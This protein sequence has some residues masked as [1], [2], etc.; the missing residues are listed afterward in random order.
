M[1]MNLGCGQIYCDALNADGC[2]TSEMKFQIGNNLIQLD[3][4]SPQG[5]QREERNRKNQRKKAFKATQAS[6]LL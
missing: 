4:L 5:L 2:I 6:S 3:K 1:Y